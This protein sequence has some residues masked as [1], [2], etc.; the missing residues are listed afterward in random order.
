MKKDLTAE[1]SINGI[2]VKIDCHQLM[3]K[4][5]DV[6]PDEE[7]FQNLFEILAKSSSSKV[8]LSVARKENINN[9]TV[10]V[11]LQDNNVKVLR[12]LVQSEAGQQTIQYEDLSRMISSDSDPELLSGIAE[13]L[14]YFS[15]C[16]SS[17]IAE[18]LISFEDPCIRFELATNFGTPKHI[19]VRLSQEQDNSIREAAKDML[20]GD[21]EEYDD[22]EVDIVIEDE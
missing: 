6:L 14:S 17:W 11:L 15:N 16:D 12:A 21:E 2:S 1:L 7:R 22:E 4:I 13:H 8:R 3:S 5:V 19:L 9:N 10:K 18:K 20:E